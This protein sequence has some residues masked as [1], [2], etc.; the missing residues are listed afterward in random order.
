[1]VINAGLAARSGSFTP[2]DAGPSKLGPARP[3]TTRAVICCLVTSECPGIGLAQ[4]NNDERQS[5]DKNIDNLF[6]VIIILSI[7]VVCGIDPCCVWEVY[8]TESVGSKGGKNKE[9]C[10]VLDR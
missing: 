10:S 7:R 5:V 9:L 8:E 3:A 1:M 6:I 4:P 2:H